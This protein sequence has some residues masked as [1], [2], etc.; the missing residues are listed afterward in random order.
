MFLRR[1]PLLLF[2]YSFLL[3]R[4]LPRTAGADLGVR[5]TAMCQCLASGP[6]ICLCYCCH[7]TRS[8]FVTLWQIEV[9]E[10]ITSQPPNKQ[11]DMYRRISHWCNGQCLPLECCEFKVI[12]LPKKVNCSLFSH[13]QKQVLGQM[14]KLLFPYKDVGWLFILPRSKK[15][16][17]RSTFQHFKSSLIT[18][19][20]FPECYLHDPQTKLMHDFRIIG[21]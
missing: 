21:I 4:L 8:A 19:T 1:F 16:H 11:S 5:C 9:G 10:W 3:L 6:L 7:F 18:S 15:H 14:L 2:S 13:P 17:K 20:V 12:V